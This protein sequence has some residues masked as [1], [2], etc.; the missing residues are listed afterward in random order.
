MARRLTLKLKLN[1]AGEISTSPEALLNLE[2]TYDTKD[3]STTVSMDFNISPYE[4]LINTT[5]WFWIYPEQLLKIKNYQGD[6][7]GNGPDLHYKM[8][9]SDNNSW[10]DGILKLP[11]NYPDVSEMVLTPPRENTGDILILSIK[12]YLSTNPLFMSVEI[13]DVE[14]DHLTATDMIRDEILEV[15]G[16]PAWQ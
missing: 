8:L 4:L 14:I 9:D 16:G 2:E 6:L 10:V 5:G 12:L 7:L 11:T 1:G 15:P 3:G 13:L